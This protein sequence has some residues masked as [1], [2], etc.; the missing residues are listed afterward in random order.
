MASRRPRC[1]ATLFRRLFQRPYAEHVGLPGLIDEDE[2]AIAAALSLTIGYGLEMADAIHLS[3]RPHGVSF[4]TFD[5]PFVKRAQRAGA[6]GVS[7]LPG[8]REG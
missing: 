8:K 5:K 4:V 6:I 3:S 7:G 2:A 1:A